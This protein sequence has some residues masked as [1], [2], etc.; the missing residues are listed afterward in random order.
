MKKVIKNLLYDTE[1]ADLIIS[2]VDPSGALVKRLYQ[3]PN[4]SFFFLYIASNTIEPITKDECREWLGLYNYDS[5][6]K[7]FGEPEHA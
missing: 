4:K 7:I 2:E 6:V 3:T 1:T 5:Y